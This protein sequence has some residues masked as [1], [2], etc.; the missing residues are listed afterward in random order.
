MSENDDNK[1][2][3]RT[4][5]G[6]FAPGSSGKPKGAR[7]KT[8]RLAEKLLGDASEGLIQAVIAK[9]MEG[10]TAAMKICMDRIAPLR[11][12]SP[13]E[14]DGMPTLDKATDAPAAIAALLRGV[15]EGKLS[16]DEAHSLAGLVEAGR[17]AIELAE[18]EQRIEALEAKQ[19]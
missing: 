15:A 17:K 16:P 18:I 2:T 4:A 7:R 13:I 9:A 5:N 12:G 10:D 11:K 19:P 14:I 1:S 3:G 6:R 8:S